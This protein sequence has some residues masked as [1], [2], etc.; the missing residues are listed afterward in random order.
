[1]AYTK[2]SLKFA[3]KMKLHRLQYEQLGLSWNM[4]PLCGLHFITA[5]KYQLK[6]VSDKFLAFRKD[7]VYLEQG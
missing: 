3:K 6:G 7:N 5:I 1:M 2:K 4:A